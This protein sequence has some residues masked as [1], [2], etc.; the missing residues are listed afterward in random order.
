MHPLKS[1]KI[2]PLVGVGFA[3]IFLV[4]AIKL[5]LVMVYDSGDIKSK[6]FAQLR[7]E[8]LL[9]ARRGDILDRNGSLLAS[10]IASF[11]AEADLVTM[12]R[13]ALKRQD[14][15]ELTADDEERILRYARE[16]AAGLDRYLAADE[17]TLYKSLTARNGEG[18]FLSYAMLGRKEDVGY[19][20]ALKTYRRKSGLTWLIVSDDTKRYYPN[21][22][23]LAQSLGIL[24]TENKG[25]FGLEAYY[26]DYLAGIDGLKISEVDKYSEDILLTEPLITQPVDGHTLVTTIDEKIQQIAEEAAAEGLRN[27]EAK[28]VHIIVTNPKNGEILA[29]VT[30]PGFDLNEPYALE[31][32]QELLEVWKNNAISD[33]YEPGSTFKIITMAAALS[34]GVV[35]EDDVFHCPGF[36]IV[37]GVRI[38]CHNKE[39]HGDQDYFDI[40]ANSCNP[41]FIELGLRLGPEKLGE[42]TEKFGLGA[43]L[44]IDL[45]GEAAGIMDFSEKTTNYSLANK[46]IGQATM[47]TSLQLINDLNTVINGG[48]RTTPHFLKEIRKTAADGTYKVV[49]TWQEPQSTDILEDEPARILQEM[50]ENSVASGGS[51]AARIEGLRVMGK[52]GTAQKVNP[53]TGKYE[54][55][56]SSFVGAAPA[57]DPKISVFVAVDEPG[58]ERTFGSQ[59]AAPLAKRIIQASIDY[60]DAPGN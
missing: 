20:E 58:T 18:E 2:A 25:R 40:L 39:G 15:E 12:R 49:E 36:V 11:Q 23:M 33:A 28:G 38:N 43:R 46:A 34:E 60:L 44:G 45:S 1:K 26:E 37:D 8:S 14:V 21:H 41:G 5:I 31:D 19:L 13:S 59:V 51:R 56:V 7:S 4:L 55:Y 3:I 24:N 22:G 29:M 32:G 53:D 30:S 16:W 52:T 50:L 6:A 48:V 35:D 47:T 17:E 27:N 10:S 54:F 42:W 9:P 57:D